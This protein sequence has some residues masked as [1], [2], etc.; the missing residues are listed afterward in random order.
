MPSNSVSICP[1]V[2]ALGIGACR[3]E[4]LLCEG[5]RSAG[6]RDRDPEVIYR[7][8]ARREP[9]ASAALGAG[10]AIPHARIDRIDHRGHA[11]A[12]NPFG[13]RLPRPDHKL[14]APVFT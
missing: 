11:P 9:A 14:V 4:N 3:A 6:S 5:A 13:H 1:H 10:V 7:A 8:L 12:Q 2:A